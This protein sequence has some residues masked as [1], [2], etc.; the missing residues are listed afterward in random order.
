MAR[1]SIMVK[2]IK[3]Q[4]KAVHCRFLLLAVVV[5]TLLSAQEATR[6][7]VNGFVEVYDPYC[8]LQERLASRGLAEVS[9]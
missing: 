6:T 5:P 1:I 9:P 7:T 4:S 2:S 8:F 3:N